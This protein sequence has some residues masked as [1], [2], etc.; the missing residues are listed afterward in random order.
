MKI[1]EIDDDFVEITNILREIGIY[2]VKKM[3]MN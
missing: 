2:H 1:V 3:M